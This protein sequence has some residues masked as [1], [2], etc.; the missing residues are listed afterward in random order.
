MAWREH[1]QESPQGPNFN[2]SLQSLGQLG[3]A[4]GVYADTWGWHS[5]RPA[6]QTKQNDMKRLIPTLSALALASTLAFAE[7]P[8]SPPPGSPPPPPP[9]GGRPNPEEIFKH[10]DTNG[11][12]ALSLEEFKASPRGQKDPAKAEEAFK[13]M[14]TDKNGS[15]SLEE[16]KAGHHGPPPG[17]PGGG[18]GGKRGKKPGGAAQ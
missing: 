9:G 8:P 18:P 3:R 7:E 12:G 1:W 11:D 4:G 16:F 15:L 2:N 14:D 13:R 5:V 10:L 17:G 6:L